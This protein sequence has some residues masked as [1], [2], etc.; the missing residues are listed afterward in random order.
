[1]QFITISNGKKTK[2][3]SEPTW[4][5]EQDKRY[6]GWKATGHVTGTPST[7]PFPASTKEIVQQPF[8]PPEVQSLRA[9]QAGTPPVVDAA[10]EVYKDPEP[11]P[12]VAQPVAAAPALNV[13]RC[14]N[15][16]GW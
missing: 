11:A 16:H 1:M 3:I 9:A 10:G 8:L 2:A 4:D 5:R 6:K 15:A 7:R 14:W 13:A 12:Q